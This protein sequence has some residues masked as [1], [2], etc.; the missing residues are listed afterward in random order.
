MCGI[1]GYKGVNNGIPV[2]LNGLKSLEYRGYDSAGI[3]YKKDNGY[4]ALNA[5]EILFLACTILFIPYTFLNGNECQRKST[6]LISIYMILYYFIKAIIIYTYEKKKN[7]KANSD[8]KEIIEKSDKELEK[9]LIKK[10][11]NLIVLEEE[12]NNI[13]NLT[14]KQT[15]MYNQIMIGVANK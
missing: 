7:V 6:I 9:I 10:S 2:L 3:A 12:K 14:R 4:I 11:T 5:L 8:I 13:N 1:V 15:S